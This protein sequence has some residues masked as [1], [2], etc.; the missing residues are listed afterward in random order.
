MR[1]C[2]KN[3]MRIR[4]ERKELKKRDPDGSEELGEEIG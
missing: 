2:E 1:S 4:G 3:W